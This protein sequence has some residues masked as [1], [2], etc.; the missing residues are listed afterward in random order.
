MFAFRTHCPTCGRVT[1]DVDA[2]VITLFT[3]PDGALTGQ[4]RITFDCPSC[5]DL[6]TLEAMAEDIPTLLLAGMH[7]T[8]SPDPRSS[9]PAGRG[10]ARPT[11]E[12]HAGAA[13][14]APPIT[15]D[16]LLEFHEQLERTDW[17]RELLGG[18]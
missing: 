18:G 2:A 9:H 7:L 13:P 17:A 15:R 5:D 11:A 8:I 3:R 6:V 14:E 4:P 1:T 16:E 10:R 12:Q